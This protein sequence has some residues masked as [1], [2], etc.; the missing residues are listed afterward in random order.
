MQEGLKLLN[1]A[2]REGLEAAYKQIFLVLLLAVG[3][4]GIKL[5]E[6]HILWNSV[7][8]LRIVIILKVSAEQHDLHCATMKLVAAE[9]WERSLDYLRREPIELPKTLRQ[10]AHAFAALSWWG[11]HHACRS[12]AFLSACCPLDLA[13]KILHSLQFR[14]ARQ[15]RRRKIRIRRKK[16]RRWRRWRRRRRNRRRRRGNRRRG[17]RRRNRIR[18]KTRNRTKKKKWTKEPHRT[19][20]KKKKKKQQRNRRRR[21]KERNI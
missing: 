16:R 7:C 14:V 13:E 21:R 11:H 3:C 5:Q 4:F 6:T 17:S 15:R 1:S 20:Q 18:K 9:A 10:D 8:I 2:D 19:K 12:V